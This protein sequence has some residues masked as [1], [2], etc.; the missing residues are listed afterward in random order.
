MTKMVRKEQLRETKKLKEKIFLQ[1]KKIKN[2]LIIDEEK[3]LC[4][5]LSDAL[6]EKNYNVLIANT[7][8]EGM[9]C[10]KKKLPDLVLLDLKLP[11]GDGIKILPK[12]KKINPETAVIIISAYVSE[13]ARQMAKRGG[14]F[15]IINKP[16]TE[17]DILRSIKALS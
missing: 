8:R 17:E 5:L 7:K 10:F 9:A 3:D 1:R 14:A 13:E 16:F 2:I 11:D 6:T 4:L 15:T 12:I